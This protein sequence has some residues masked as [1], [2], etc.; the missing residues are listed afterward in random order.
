MIRVILRGGLGNQMFQYA[1]GLALSRRYRTPLVLDAT[2]LNDHFPRP[3]FTYRTY[4]L[5]VFTLPPT[6]TALSKISAAAPVPG[7]WLGLDLSLVKA[8]D[9]LGMQKLVREARSY[10][11]DP[12]VGA[13]GGD[14]ALW[15]F[16]Q[17]PK[18]FGG[19]EGEVRRAF[20]FRDPMTGE[21]LR[22]SADIQKT[23][24]VLLH[25]RRADYLMPKYAKVYGATDLGYYRRAVSYVAGKVA[26][27][28]FFVFSDDIAWC[29]EN[30]KL[31]FP[32]EYVD[33]ASS[34]PKASFHLHLMSLCRHNIVTNSSFSWW[35]AW[36]N[37]NPGKIIVAPE[38]WE[39]SD[40][41]LD[42][43]PDGWIKR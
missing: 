26:N 35:G 11:F 27:P 28:R 32:T 12:R 14:V 1:A 7:L 42:I 13:A 20:R 38:R 41:P 34:G 2:Y 22:I 17:T 5:D 24:S 21:A 3:Q 4:D 43:I 23:N 18:Y 39:V 19:I 36:L 31:E 9:I 8:R 30:I 37:E 40:Y 25:V 33:A 16:W 29:R 10:Q 6:F 15:G